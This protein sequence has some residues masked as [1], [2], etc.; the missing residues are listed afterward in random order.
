MNCMVLRKTSLFLLAG[1]V[2]FAAGCGDSSP[3]SR[4]APAAGSASSADSKN[5]TVGAFTLL[6]EPVNT[7]AR[8]I[9]D[10]NLD[11]VNGNKDISSPLNKRGT[12]VLSG[13]IADGASGK[14]VERAELVL[15]GAKSY[16]LGLAVGLPRPDV[17]EV[18]KS[19]AFKSSGFSSKASF[20]S[21][22]PGRYDV[23]LQGYIDG[24]LVSCSKN[25]TLT[26]AD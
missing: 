24:E 22:E 19:A 23:V 10:C 16:V 21:L 15:K 25:K 7:S 5:D 17:V 12:Y 26:V 8:A 18:K 13:W 14:P 4:P 2:F 11:G 1:F 3:E 20:Q 6:S 9:D